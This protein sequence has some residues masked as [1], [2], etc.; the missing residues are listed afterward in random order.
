METNNTI[1]KCKCGKEFKSL[2]S[3]RNHGRFCDKYE[4]FALD[5]EN[6]KIYYESDSEYNQFCSS[7]YKISKYKVND[8]L[9]KCECG[10]EFSNYQSLNGHFSYCQI[11]R[12][13]KTPKHLVFTKDN[14][15]W[16]WNKG[17]TKY[18]HLSV[19]KQG[20]SLSNNIKSGKIKVPWTGKKHTEET[21]QKLRES[22]LKYLKKFKN[23]NGPRYNPIGCQFIDEINLL[24]NWNLKHAMNGGEKKILRYYVDGYDEELNIVFE[25]DEPR[26]YNKDNIL[27]EKDLIRQ[28]NIIKELNCDFYRYNEQLKYFYKIN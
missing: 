24:M 3:L 7:K 8:N 19:A 25:Y 22:F 15:G 18:T 1:F 13:G 20:L 28:N 17:Y 5:K 4:K 27:K 6:N 12:N 23:F 14:P 2:N 10:K 16:G 21:K 26:H 9:Y 11:H